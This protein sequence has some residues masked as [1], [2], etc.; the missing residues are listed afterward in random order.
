[1]KKVYQTII[2]PENGNCMEACIASLL[3]INLS[4]VPT[5]NKEG[6]KWYDDCQKFLARYDLQI[7]CF[8]ANED[9][10][11]ELLL[12]YYIVAVK[13]PNFK[14]AGHVV[15]MKKGIVIH[16][17]NPNGKPVDL[18][19]IDSIEVLVKKCEVAV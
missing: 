5:F 16:D 3:E 11:L 7:L 18:S 2:D 15:I 12:G 14:E 1:M 19:A 4:D 13:S 17:P 9:M 8:N 10:D 6:H